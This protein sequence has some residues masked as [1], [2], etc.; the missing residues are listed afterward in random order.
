MSIVYGQTL[1]CGDTTYSV[2]GFRSAEEALWAAF[3]GMG[4]AY[5]YGNVTRR[6]MLKYL[7]KDQVRRI[8]RI[9]ANKLFA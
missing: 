6:S 8:N 5:K 3:R 1:A 2:N 7:T 4:F 9:A